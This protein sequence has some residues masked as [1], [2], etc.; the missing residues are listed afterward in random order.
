[1]TNWA[2]KKRNKTF[3]RRMEEESQESKMRQT[4]D[5]E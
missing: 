1:M 2:T 5:K 4:K 3:Q